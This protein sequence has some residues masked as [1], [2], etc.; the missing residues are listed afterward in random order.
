MFF[1]AA[2]FPA[3]NIQFVFYDLD[4]LQAAFNEFRDNVWGDDL[5]AAVAVWKDNFLVAQILPV[6]NPQTGEY[7]P[8]LYLIPPP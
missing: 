5:V 4:D 6:Y 8:K 1:F 7:E 3:R 2:P